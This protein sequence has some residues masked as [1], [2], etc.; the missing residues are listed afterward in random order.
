[1]RLFDMAQKIPFSNECFTTLAATKWFFTSLQEFILSNILKTFKILWISKSLT[2][3]R[4]C[5]TKWP[6]E[7]KSF[8]HRSQ[9]NGRSAFTPLLWL[10]WW[11][12]RFPLSGNDFPHVSQAYGRSP[13]W[14]RLIWLTSDSL[15]ENDLLHTVQINGLSGEWCCWM[16]WKTLAHLYKIN[17]IDFLFFH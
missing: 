9:R 15:R 1:M 4:R 13:V 3:L 7:M 10:R 17:C 8:G 14:Q 2:W 6:F 11:K 12:S 16:V 5:E